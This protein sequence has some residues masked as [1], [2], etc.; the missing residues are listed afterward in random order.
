MFRVCRF[1]PVSSRSRSSMYSTLPTVSLKE[2]GI[3]LIVCDMAGTTVD[4]GGI[5]Y[6]ALRSAMNQ[7]GLAVKEE[8]MD[9]WHGAQKIEVITHFANDRG[10]K[11]VASL[12]PLIDTDF[13]KIASEA[14]FGE[15]KENITVIH[16][17]LFSFFDNLRSNGIKVALNTGYPR[18]I[19]DGLLD[20]LKMRP[21][22]D[23]FISAQDVR[24][25]R[26]SPFM[27]FHLMEKNNVQD[28]RKVA[29]VGD[30]VN[31]VLEGKNAGCG[32]VV[33]VLSGADKREQ[34]IAAGA[35]LVLNNVTEL[36]F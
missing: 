10:V 9:P 24:C 17:T 27:I 25:G 7:H 6:S 12:I 18:K 4:E 1:I 34:L 21:H 35:D 13:Q 23:S 26:P 16:P 5:V 19:Q 15:G 2:R 14:Y 20:N 30:T 31:D 3:E 36:K 29:K 33:G 22:I 32:L 11:D 28:V 8:E